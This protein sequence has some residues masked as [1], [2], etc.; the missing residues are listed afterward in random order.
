MRQMTVP[1]SNISAEERQ[2]LVWLTHLMYGLHTLSFFS[3]GIF[4]VVALIL[5]YIKRNELPDDFFR[6]HFRWQARSFWFTLMWLLLTLPLWA[7]FVFPGWAAWTFIG[8]WYLYR[9]VRGWWM[10]FEKRPMP[11]PMIAT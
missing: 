4:S 10:F 1:G 9:F 6:S 5:N 8:L 2:T 7:F 3:L 11:V